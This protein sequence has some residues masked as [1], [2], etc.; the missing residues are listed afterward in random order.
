M[1]SLNPVVLYLAANHLQNHMEQC[2]IYVI[3]HLQGIYLI[4]KPEDRGRG[5]INQIYHEAKRRY[6]D[7]ISC[8]DNGYKNFLFFLFFI[9]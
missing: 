6:N 1:R 7:F 3:T 8:L 5:F 9:F 2:K 4:Y